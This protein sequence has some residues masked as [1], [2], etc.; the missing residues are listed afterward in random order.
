[1][2][3]GE[4]FSINIPGIET[5]LKHTPEPQKKSKE[6][7]KTESPFIIADPEVF[8]DPKYWLPPDIFNDEEFETLQTLNWIPKEILEEKDPE[9]KQTLLR[10]FLL[11][12]TKGHRRLVEKEKARGQVLDPKA[13]VTSQLNIADYVG[14]TATAL[15]KEKLNAIDR[16]REYA[17]AVAALAAAEKERGTHHLTGLLNGKGVDHIF[18]KEM[19]RA[20][21]ESDPG[22]M[23][24][25]RFDADNF[26]PI[27]DTYGHL[28]GDSVLQQIGAALESSTRPGDYPL[29]FSGDEFGLLLTDVKPANGKTLEQTVDEIIKRQI[30]AVEKIIRPDGQKQ[31]MSAGY[32]IIEKDTKGYFTDYDTDADTAAYMAKNLKYAVKDGERIHRM[33]STR[34]VNFAESAQTLQDQLSE[35]QRRALAVEAGMER[36]FRET[37][38]ALE[39]KLNEGIITEKELTELRHAKDLLLH[40]IQKM[41]NKKSAPPGPIAA[42][43][44][45]TEEQVA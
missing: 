10:E 30:E 38:A 44:E 9:S 27:N 24:V 3:K 4:K 20:E 2:Q 28:T 36:A 12:L 31:T 25:V 15:A 19:K 40:L 5:N 13:F 32:R 14:D 21:R 26:K 35:G 11:A 7:P 6:I 23:V 29:H 39:K 16:A 34:I 17:L 41:L 1:M 8:E 37:I 42:E 22:H 45:D 33:G 18:T 43:S